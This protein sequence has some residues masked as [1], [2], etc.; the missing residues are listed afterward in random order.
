[1]NKKNMTCC[2]TGHRQ[3]PPSDYPKI[4]EQLEDT[5]TMLI[6]DKGVKYFGVG[7]ALGFDT[8]VAK[9]ILKIK[10]YSPDIKL[11][12]VLPF[13]DQAKKWS[14]YDKQVYEQIKRQ[15]DKVVYTDEYYKGNETYYKRNRHLVDF[16][17]YCIC[18]MISNS[19]G[20]GYTYNYALEKGLTIY[21]LAEML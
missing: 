6:N 21:N 2:F 19:S 8:L 16:S 4:K 14:N 7:G 1:M 18:Y 3:I 10:E 9:V 15:A 11:I 17:D 20:T 12:L 5:L 13:K